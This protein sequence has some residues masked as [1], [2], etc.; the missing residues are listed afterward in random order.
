MFFHARHQLVICLAIG[1]TINATPTPLEHAT[2]QFASSEI[3]REPTH[4]QDTDP[5]AS[6]AGGGRRPDLPSYHNKHVFDNVANDDMQ[7]DSNRLIPGKSHDVFDDS[8]ADIPQPVRG[9]YGAPLLGPH[10]VPLEEQNLD[11]LRPPQTD[12]G[13]V[14]NFKWPFSLSHNRLT[15]GGWARQQNG[16]ISYPFKLGRTDKRV[17]TEKQMPVAKD[18]AGK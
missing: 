10:N 2:P 1:L 7:L 6:I 16:A 15:T 3:T 5:F 9:K 4:H 14:M 12:A 11:S 18:L 8:Q 17:F 13:S